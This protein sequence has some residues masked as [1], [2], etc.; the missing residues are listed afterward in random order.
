MLNSTKVFLD[1]GISK[2]IDFSIIREFLSHTSDKRNIVTEFVRSCTEEIDNNEDAFNKISR[3]EDEGLLKR[4]LIR[5][6]AVWGNKNAGKTRS[7]E[8]VNES[9]LFLDFI[10]NIASRDFD[11]YTQL[12]FKKGSLKVAVL[13]VAKRETYE[14]KGVTPYLRRIREGFANG[15][16]TFYLLA[17][18]DKIEILEKV[19]GE[20]VGK[21]FFNLIN[22]PAVYKDNNGRDTI[23]YCIEIDANA[24][25]A[26]SYQEL[27]HAV[28]E[29]KEIEL[30]INNVYRDELLCDY[31]GIS[32]KIPR[33]EI[34]RNPDLRLSCYY[35]KGMSIIGIPLRNEKDYYVCSVLNTQSNPQILFNHNYEIGHNVLVVVQNV[36]DEVIDFI[37]KGTDQQCVGYRREMTYS[38]FSF[39][40]ELYPV[41]TEIELQIKE[42]DYIQNRLVLTN[43]NLLDPWKDLKFKEGDNVSCTV[44]NKKDNFI[45]TE[46]EQGIYGILPFSEMTWFNSEIQEKKK[47]QRGSTIC[48]RILKINNS[49]KIVILSQK[50][51]ESPYKK[52]FNTLN[53]DKNVSV[54]IESESSYGI[55]GVLDNRYDV[56]IPK[57]E[58]YIG[59]NHHRYRINTK[60]D[61]H[62]KSVDNNGRSLIGT[63]KPFIKHPL[64]EF[65][66]RFEEGQVLLNLRPIRFYEK[67]SY[68]QIN[69]GKGKH[70][71]ALLQNFDV[72]GSCFV[73]NPEKIFSNNN[74]CPLMIKQIN[75]ERNV[76]LLS[77]KDL[78]KRNKERASS[79][80]YG[81][82]KSGFVIGNKRKNYIVI[83]EGLWVEVEVKST[84]IYNLGDKIEVMLESIGQY[85]DANN[86]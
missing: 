40:H 76:V 68:F 28:E 52:Y 17:R 48:A 54:Y 38:R 79:L 86:M 64:E 49:D 61:V 84:K 37:V 58:T 59:S 56:F 31:N 74:S 60:M 19:Y 43:I 63:F 42:I 18:N 33:E 13:L 80:K 6:Y 7:Q 9:K 45:E 11:E 12:V 25:L 30:T 71:E 50:D 41:G 22:G 82:V 78:T 32:I 44:Y 21:G 4:V 66:R 15:I 57:S 10:Y 53:E 29:E 1:E 81:E 26:K 55:Q 62:I 69:Y 27:S 34:T 8:L 67:H 46:L 77:L 51:I 72:S 24:D 85:I 75:M 70:I 3:I 39:L 14:T 35:T 83:L 36:D 2:A 65:K 5:E 20:L 23:C 16:N 47:I 73:S